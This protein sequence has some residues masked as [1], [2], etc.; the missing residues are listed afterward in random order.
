MV[1]KTD[2]FAY[3]EKI[4]DCEILDKLYCKNKEC[5]FYRHRC[6]VNKN[7]IE[8]DIIKYSINKK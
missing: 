8:A 5:K 2:C 6:E 7:K 3:D 4:K 1:V